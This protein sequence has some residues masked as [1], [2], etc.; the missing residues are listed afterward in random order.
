MARAMAVV[1]QADHEADEAAKAPLLREAA[2]AKQQALA[3]AAR[4]QAAYQASVEI[5]EAGA[6]NRK[7]AVQAAALSEELQQAR[8]QK[9]HARTTEALRELKT[10]LDEANGPAAR[11]DQQE[12]MR[13]SATAAG[14]EAARRMRQATAQRE[15]E[16][17]LAD[18]IGRLGRETEEA[19]GRRKAELQDQLSTL[20]A[21]R[22]A[23][24]DEV[25]AAFQQAREAEDTA[26]LL[27]GQ[28]ALAGYLED[29]PATH[30]A[31]APGQ[32]AIAALVQRV[33]QVRAENRALQ[34][35]PMH[36]PM[37]MASAE[38]RERRIFN[39]GADRDVLADGGNGAGGS[40][41]QVR[42]VQTA[43]S[44]MA[45]TDRADR[46]P[47]TRQAET[48]AV[49]P[50][51]E[52]QEG[53]VEPAY[54]EAQASGNGHVEGRSPAEGTRTDSSPGS[55]AAAAPAGTGT[56]GLQDLATAD[57]GQVQTAEARNGESEGSAGRTNASTPEAAQASA[58]NDGAAPA[59]LS[60]DE[61]AFLLA[62]KLAELE[63]LRQ[64]EK[65]RSRRD[66]LDQAIAGQQALIAAFQAGEKV[67]GQE[68]G[69][70]PHSHVYTYLDFDMAILDE[71]LAEE[72]FPGFSLRRKAIEEGTASPG[73]KAAMLH[74][75]EMQ[76]IDSIDVHA[77][78]LLA[79]LEQEPQLAD[80]LLPRLERWNQLKAVHATNAAEVLAAVDREYAA[81]ETKAMED[82]E[83]AART[84][85]QRPVAGQSI[86][87]TPH[88]DAYIA[89]KEDLDRIYASPVTPRSG[90]STEAIAL[91]DRDLEAAERMRTEIDSMQRV[92]GEMPAGKAYDKL[93]QQTDRKIDDL[94][95][96]QVD[97][98]Q[99]LAY[100]GRNEMAVAQDSAKLLARSLSR[101]GIAANEP[102]WLMAGAYVEAAEAAVAKARAFRKQADNARDIFK[103]NSLYR[104][105]YAEELKALR[106]YDRSHTVRNYLLSGGAAPG[107]ALAYEEVEQRM[108][109]AAFAQ[110]A[111][112]LPATPARSAGTGA[113]EAGQAPASTQPATGQDAEAGQ[114]AA[115]DRLAQATVQQ[116]EESEAALPPTGAPDPVATVATL[117]GLA[118]APA[119]SIVLSEYLDSYYYLTPDE[120]RTV[121]GGE[122]ESRYFMMKGRA[123]QVREEAMVAETEA[124]GAESLA[125]MLRGEAEVL[126]ET[127]AAEQEPGQLQKME[128]RAVALA[129]RSDSL[130]GLAERLNASA[131]LHDAQAATL[132]QGMP[133]A[134]S[135]AIMDLEQGRRRTEPLLARTRPRPASPETTMPR[136]EPAAERPE[137]VPPGE[138]PPAQAVASDGSPVSAQHEEETALEQ[139]RQ[140]PSIDRHRAGQPA[141]E[142][143]SPAAVAGEGTAADAVP[144]QPAEALPAAS[145]E[146]GPARMPGRAPRMD[147]PSIPMDRPLAQDV[148]QFEERIAPREEAI[149]LDLPLPAGIVYKVQVG[150]FRNEL[151]LE[152]FSD[153]TPVTGEHAGNGLVR[154]TAG[155][156]T[157]AESASEAGARVRERG[158]HDAF[159]V[160]YMDGER[161]PLRDAM[162]AEQ[163]RP[164]AD[165]AALP[166]PATPV[167]PSSVAPAAEE[168]AGGVNVAPPPVTPIPQAAPADA[169]LAA[170]PP[171]AAE[172]LASFR[173]AGLDTAYYN[174][175]DAAPAKQV[176]AVQGLFFTVQVGVY[177]KPTPLDRLFN[178]TPLNSELTATG[179]IRY[180]TGIYREEAQAA[181][182]RTGAVALGVTDAFITAYLNGKRIPIRDAR[183]LLA[184]FGAEVLV[185]PTQV[186]GP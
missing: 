81:S 172:V 152:A 42:D 125:S 111:P 124:D 44:P 146:D 40:R 131:T 100:I 104:Q 79:T 28:A 68:V 72:A 88:N 13:R 127:P 182:R 5:G 10:A 129:Q 64:G 177:S 9:D 25:E 75:L 59:S 132:M 86:S 12:R 99:R 180:T 85:E 16:T 147:R 123:M 48:G 78:R 37:E 174:D 51:S 120:H 36:A 160:A 122:E 31:E 181:Q 57:T 62:N 47:G 2:M 23:M 116:P 134:R 50:A 32:G 38:D 84:P 114:D 109:P 159:V 145:R 19:K 103:R 170:Y 14:E 87:Q 29:A 162:R 178:V 60:A 165:L 7:R 56:G 128:A 105:A 108:F 66:S 35:D 41:T 83:L 63:Q 49:Q 137:A 6:L 46:A 140:P 149:P 139:Q 154:Y 168:G 141:P 185:A 22:D 130:R 167:P 107:E 17:L 118:H 94:L 156:F 89:I 71:E 98:G 164:V 3:A 70:L 186:T 184:R 54:T 153:M 58:G 161:V 53:L 65:D 148:F 142:P 157:T 135:A 20:Q 52:G 34:I 69:A 144:A 175:P 150:A 110:A 91:K 73:E 96:L 138:V 43:A 183:A 82:A 115:A 151:P 176:E 21:Q 45:T 155:L 121:M 166:P 39:W 93:R 8:S 26:A 119:D 102:L 67:D 171:T 76:L 133:A 92:L 126:R 30:P 106:D 113:Q 80:Q 1:K 143:H 61:Q 179:K 97:L 4:A 163:A 11:I 101:Q 173:P 136:P 95:I 112:P 169:V 158:Y 90:R 74:A 18:R 15:E 55:T 77:A 24:H 117:P 33:E 27:R